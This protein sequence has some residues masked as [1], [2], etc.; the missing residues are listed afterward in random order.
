[1]ANGSFPNVLRCKSKKDVIWFLNEP[2]HIIKDGKPFL[3][4]PNHFMNHATAQNHTLIIDCQRVVKI[5]CVVDGGAF[6]SLSPLEPIGQCQS[7]AV[8]N[9]RRPQPSSHRLQMV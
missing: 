6:P 8:S 2:N 3:N 7:I 4:E 9:G 5:N 1:M